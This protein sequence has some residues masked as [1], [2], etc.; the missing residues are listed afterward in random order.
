MVARAALLFF[1]IS[2]FLISYE[3][4]LG[5]LNYTGISDQAGTREQIAM[6]KMC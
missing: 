5:R 3:V 1:V 4:V 2:G 6:I